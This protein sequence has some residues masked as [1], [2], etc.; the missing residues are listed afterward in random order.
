MS[1]TKIN[2]GWQEFKEYYWRQKDEDPLHRFYSHQH[3]QEDNPDLEKFKVKMLRALKDTPV[4]MI[5]AALGG[6]LLENAI[7]KKPS[8]IFGT[9]ATYM[10]Y[11]TDVKPLAALGLGMVTASYYTHRMDGKSNSQEDDMQSSEEVND[12]FQSEADYQKENFPSS[13]MFQ[14][15]TDGAI[16]DYIPTSETEESEDTHSQANV[17][18][19][20]YKLSFKRPTQEE[21]EAD[22]ISN[23]LY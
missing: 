6:V 7:G 21:E 2:T 10:G 4:A 16:E 1:K 13:E 9:F 18:R 22:D 17:P 5:S 15:Q 11:L 19:F 14:D 12:V 8:F 3:T 20:N 23:K